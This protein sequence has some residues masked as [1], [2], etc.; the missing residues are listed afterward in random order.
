MVHNLDDDRARLLDEI[1][2]G[3][4]PGI[5]WKQGAIDY[6][7]SAMQDGQGQIQ[8][9]HLVKPFL[10][11]P[12]FS[13]FFEDMTS[14]LLAA[15]RLALPPSS[16]I[17]DVACGPGWVV[18]YFAKLGHDVLGIDICQPLLDCAR[19]RIAEDPR[20]PFHDIPLKARFLLHDI[21]AA[22]LAS[23]EE[24][25]AATI[26][27]ALHHFYDPI[28]ALENIRASLSA[29]GLLVIVEG[30]KPPAGSPWELEQLE[31]MRKYHTL[32]RPFTRSQLEQ[33]L[34]L[35]GF[36][37]FEFSCPL[38]DLFPLHEG[39]LPSVDEKIV[40]NISH[41]FVIASP[42]LSK[43]TSL[44][45]GH[46]APLVFVDGFHAQES[47]PGG[48]AFRWSTNSSRILLRQ[49][50]LTLRFQNWALPPG[51]SQQILILDA[52][53]SVAELTL[54][55]PHDQPE[56]HLDARLQGK[57]LRI[58]SDTWTCPAWNG[59][60]DQRLLSFVVYLPA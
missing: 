25:D 59:I 48:A 12:D 49:P 42:S 16:R 40:S 10:G 30:A 33:L 23:G 4:P 51:H 5:D 35:A 11:G 19:Q 46:A 32:E 1:N 56:V 2:A 34:T 47:L 36:P 39:V 45:P 50:G 38:S 15:K 18:H 7:A 53:Q 37:H 24:F 6:V 9:Y 26:F 55:S 13:P 58:L 3:L 43:L 52:A 21:E 29:Q 57:L 41:N 8:Q 17:L 20:G 31:V 54:R 14:F 44:F 22:P 27:S 60:Q 28:A